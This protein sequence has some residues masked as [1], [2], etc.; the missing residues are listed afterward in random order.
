MFRHSLWRTVPAVRPFPVTPIETDR[1]RLSAP[2]RADASAMIEHAN[3]YEVARRLARLPHPYGA[4]EADHFF[5]HIATE[6]SVWKVARR[7]D[8]A[9]LGLVGLSGAAPARVEL[10]YWYGRAHW[11]RGYATEAGRAVLAFARTQAPT[12]HFISGYFA[13][14]PAS[15]NVLRKLGFVETGRS[16]QPCLA[17]SRDL[18]HVDMAMTAD[19]PIATGETR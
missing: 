9:F 12:T 2:D 6:E 18:P 17:R 4:R 15:G 19:M 16:T 13:D 3:D 11:G 10:G 7:S 5:E 8:G 1:L 14:N